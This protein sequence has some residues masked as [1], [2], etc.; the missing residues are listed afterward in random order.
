M[1]TATIEQAFL[2]ELS[3]TRDSFAERMF[4]ISQGLSLNIS[5]ADIPQAS[6]K[7]TEIFDFLKDIEVKYPLQTITA[8]QFIFLTGALAFRHHCQS[9]IYGDS[10]IHCTKYLMTLWPKV[11]KK[12]D[13][14]GARLDFY[15]WFIKQCPK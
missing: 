13:V 4:C 14:K 5:V 6:A 10:D 12:F 1:E 3:K 7:E 9:I 15:K 2:N 8:S 11:R